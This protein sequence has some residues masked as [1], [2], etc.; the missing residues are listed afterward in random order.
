LVSKIKAVGQ[1][2]PTPAPARPQSHSQKSTTLNLRANE[3]RANT[4][5]NRVPDN[6][7]ETA[8]GSTERDRPV[9]PEHLLPADLNV[10][11]AI[12]ISRSLVT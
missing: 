12:G 8:I 5:G 10:D 6:D 7:R 3:D 1:N 11:L 4:H 2:I 9:D